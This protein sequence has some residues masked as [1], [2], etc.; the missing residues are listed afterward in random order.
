MFKFKT[1]N[2]EGRWFVLDLFKYS[3][4][5]MLKHQCIC[6]GIYNLKLGDTV[7]IWCITLT[8]MK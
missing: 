8:T 1:Y 4:H 2:N 7:K 3:Y 5:I 6:F